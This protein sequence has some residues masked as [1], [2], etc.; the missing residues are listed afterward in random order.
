[1]IARIRAAIFF[2][3]LFGSIFFF[4]FWL[5][6]A[7]VIFQRA[8]FIK[9]M[10]TTWLGFF[11]PVFGLKREVRGKENLADRGTIF[12]V[13]HQSWLDIPLM[14]VGVRFPAFLAKQEISSW[15]WFGAAM[16]VLHCVFV[17]RSDRRSRSEVGQKVRKEVDAGID[18]CIF[19]EGTRSVDGRLQ[20]FQGGAFRMAIDSG[21]T[22]TPV[23]LD[24][25]W[26]ILNKKTF[27]LY[28]GTIRARILEPIDTSLPENREPK[29][30]MA[31]VQS[32]MEETLRQMRAEPGA[33]GRFEG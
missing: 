33:S 8:S 30:L 19:P 25:T 24:E 3:T 14:M 6:P 4:G 13:N 28:P 7:A 20:A 31:L 16:R 11:M 2:G 26:W 23:V 21:A 29:V 9:W 27:Q 15:P 22:V 5:I 18:F 32:R 17:D 12:V 1:M 10:C